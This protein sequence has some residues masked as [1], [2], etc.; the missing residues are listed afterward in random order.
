MTQSSFFGSTVLIYAVVSLNGYTSVSL[1]FSLFFITQYQL[2]MFAVEANKKE[3]L[4]LLELQ[5][6]ANYTEGM[7]LISN[8]FTQLAKKSGRT[9]QVEA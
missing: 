1:D 5:V 9:F 6:G 8:N 2:Q 3:S 7:V 4:F